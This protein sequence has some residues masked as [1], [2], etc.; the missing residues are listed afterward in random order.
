MEQQKTFILII[1]NVFCHGILNMQET[2]Y[3]VYPTKEILRYDMQHGF[4]IMCI[5]YETLSC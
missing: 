4:E 2:E 3:G 1:S 5:F